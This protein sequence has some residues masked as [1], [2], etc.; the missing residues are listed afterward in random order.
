MARM[1]TCIRLL[2]VCMWHELKRK[3]DWEKKE[4]HKFPLRLLDF[5]RPLDGRKFP[6]TDCT[7]TTLQLASNCWHVSM[8]Q[9]QRNRARSHFRLAS[10]Q[11]FSGSANR[12]QNRTCSH[13]RLASCRSA[14]R[15]LVFLIYNCW[16]SCCATVADHY[17]SCVASQRFTSSSSETKVIQQWLKSISLHIYF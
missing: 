3:E 16:F 1:Y 10:T 4:R 17:L 5:A 13:L 2:H 14:N 8:H 6:T 7:Q 15:H 11:P 12:L 9:S